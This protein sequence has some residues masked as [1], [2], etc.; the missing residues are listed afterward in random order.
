MFLYYIVL[1]YRNALDTDFTRVRLGPHITMIRMRI[2]M[3]M[4]IHYNPYSFIIEYVYKKNL[5]S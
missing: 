4:N 3:N 5:V 2:T 1:N